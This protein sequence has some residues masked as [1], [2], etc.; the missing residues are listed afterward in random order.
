MATF[1]ERYLTEEKTNVPSRLTAVLRRAPLVMMTV[2]FTM[3]SAR[4]LV[5]P[6]HSAAIQG[7]AFTT[8]GGVTV[9]R[10]G[11]GA[12]PLALAILA[13]GCLI[14]ARRLLAGLYMVFTVISVVI[15]IRLA[16]IV[17][18]HSAHEAARLLAPEFVLL[19]LSIIALRL[20]SARR[21]AQPQG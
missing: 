19:T 4:Y 17:L 16:G 21:R 5:N 14:S 7:I 13:F 6:V 3:I 20:E 10:I 8:P 2:I 1:A 11:F 12:F 18:D 9:A 15:A